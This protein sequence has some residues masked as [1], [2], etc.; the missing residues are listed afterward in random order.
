M[1][2]SESQRL[3][4]YKTLEDRLGPEDAVTMMTLLPQ[5]TQELATKADLAML[6][7]ELES[8]IDGAMRDLTRTFI[9]WT[10]ASQ[11]FLVAVVG[12]LVSL[13]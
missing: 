4:L 5:D 3:H 13:R 10:V 8:K 7:A 12:L 2:V 6:K 11:T 9:G 1:T